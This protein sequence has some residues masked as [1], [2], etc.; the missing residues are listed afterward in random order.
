MKEHI[1][2]FLWFWL[3]SIMYMSAIFF[4]SAQSN[5]QIGG[6]TPDYVLH[7]LEYLLLALLLIRLLLSRPHDR[8]DFAHWQRACLAGML[9]AVAYG[10]SD[11]FHQ[12]FT[13]GRHC[14]LQDVLADSFGALLAYAAACLDYLMFTGKQT[15]LKRL[16][17]WEPLTSISYIVARLK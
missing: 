16:R 5:P 1:H 2:H 17:S 3:P 7:A 9:L 13:P 15:W 12:Y 8:H 11:E 6:D 10:V 14:S 4:L